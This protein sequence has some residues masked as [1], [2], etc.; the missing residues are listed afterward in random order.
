MKQEYKDPLQWKVKT[1]K[2]YLVWS[3]QLSPLLKLQRNKRNRTPT[4]SS[5]MPAQCSPSWVFRPTGCWSLCG[6]IIYGLII[7][8]IIH[9]GNT[10]RQIK[11]LVISRKASFN[12]YSSHRRQ[13]S[14][15]HRAVF[16]PNHAL[17]QQVTLGSTWSSR[18][19]LLREVTWPLRLAR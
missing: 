19:C 15:D 17:P 4:L 6:L 8:D 7:I 13:K 16:I 3:S 2:F 14:S 12:F 10:T 9:Q 1:P 11:L 5:A 18:F